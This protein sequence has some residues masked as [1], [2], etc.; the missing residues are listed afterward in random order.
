MWDI[1]KD[2]L[3]LPQNFL[4]AFEEISVCFS[5]YGI[6]PRSRKLGSASKQSM[7]KC[8]RIRTVLD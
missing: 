1:K 3:F 2:N 4:P 7:L 6:I 5:S 8:L